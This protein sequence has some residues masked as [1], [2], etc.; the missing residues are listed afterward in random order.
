MRK[1]TCVRMHTHKHTHLH[2]HTYM[3]TIITHAQT[4]TITHAYT[5]TFIH[6][7]IY[8]HTHTHKHNHNHK[9]KHAH[10]HT[11]THALTHT[12]THIQVEGYQDRLAVP[13]TERVAALNEDELLAHI[14]FVF[15]REIPWVRLGHEL[16][17]AGTE[18]VCVHQCCRILIES[19][20]KSGTVSFYQHA[21]VF[22]M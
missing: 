7:F 5:L 22:K 8:K 13:I 17:M 10:A 9:H 4:N 11:H 16:V 20:K 21:V 3:P 12:H 18:P 19:L 1:Y 15:S 2:T 14:L 6:H